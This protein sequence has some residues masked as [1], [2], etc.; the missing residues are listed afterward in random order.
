MTR[1][2]TECFFKY[3]SHLARRARFLSKFPLFKSHHRETIKNRQSTSDTIFRFNMSLRLGRSLGH[4][5]RIYGWKKLRKE[6]DNSTRGD[7]CFELQSFDTW[8]RASFQ[9]PVVVYIPGGMFHRWEH[10]IWS[11]YPFLNECWGIATMYTRRNN[12]SICHE[13]KY[14]L[15]R[16]WLSTRWQYQ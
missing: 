13:R 6:G 10:L 12:V 2:W 8:I 7:R 1:P 15:S 3:L 16:N 14:N 9:S 11:C 4:F 5:L